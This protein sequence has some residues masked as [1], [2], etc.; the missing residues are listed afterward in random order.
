MGSIVA[1]ILSIGRSRIFYILALAVMVF[2]G[3]LRYFP[4][5]VHDRYIL[6]S[7]LG[8]FCAQGMKPITE[9]TGFAWKRIFRCGGMPSS[10]AAVAAAMTTSLGLDF[11]WASPFF[12]VSA[13]LGG[14]VI[15]DAVTLRRVVGEHS[16]ILK[17]L[18][19]DHAKK[20]YLLGE[21]VGHTP[22]EA[23]AGVLIGIL[24]AIMVVCV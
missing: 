22:L 7:L 15:Y 11:G 9:K 21:M 1:R 8:V 20:P 12:Q 5:L 14:I 24:C 6:S 10:H 2:W 17:E 19:R 23:S 16:L 18:V 4:F 3:G 13:V